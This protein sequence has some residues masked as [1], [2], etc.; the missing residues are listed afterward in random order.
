MKYYDVKVSVKMEDDKGKIKNIGEQYLIHA[1]S[2]LDAETTITKKF[3][4]EGS[5]L[6]FTVKSIKETKFL[7]VL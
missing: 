3:V 2:C 7:E 4:D 5:N 6:D 1:A